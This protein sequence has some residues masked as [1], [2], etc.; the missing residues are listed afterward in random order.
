[1]LYLAFIIIII[2]L[3]LVTSVVLIVEIFPLNIKECP[4]EILE[5]S[6]FT[7]LEDSIGVISSTGETPDFDRKQKK[8]LVLSKE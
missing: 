8:L 2:Q 3:V 6:S 1:L 7:L 4:L 5:E